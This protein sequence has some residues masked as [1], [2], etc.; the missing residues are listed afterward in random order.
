M[1]AT[2]SSSSAPRSP[3]FPPLSPSFTP[4][5]PQI[6]SPIT[7]DFETP[8]SSPRT[9]TVQEW[10]M[11]DRQPPDGWVRQDKEVPSI[12]DQADDEGFELVSEQHHRLQAALETHDNGRNGKV[13]R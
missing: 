10:E 12:E 4:V 8:E 5:N 11:Q 6:N 1:A 9:Y 13:H 7:V 3:T 2:E